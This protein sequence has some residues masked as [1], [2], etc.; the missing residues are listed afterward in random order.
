MLKSGKGKDIR[1]HRV[2]SGSGAKKTGNPNLNFSI[3]EEDDSDSDLVILWF[4]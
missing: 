3:A 4:H 2:D 1:Y